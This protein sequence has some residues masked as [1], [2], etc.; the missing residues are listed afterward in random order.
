VLDQESV[1]RQHAKISLV[2]GDYLVEDL[3]SRN[4]TFVNSDAIQEPRKLAHG[5]RLRICELEFV[6]HNPRVDDGRLSANRLQWA[7]RETDSNSQ[8]ISM[9]EM[10]GSSSGAPSVNADAKLQAIV[11]I[12]R[13]LSKV[14]SL[15]TVLPKLLDGLFKIFSRA[16]R[17]FVL[18]ADADGGLVPKA[19]KYRQP[20]K[21]PGPIQISRTIVNQVMKSQQAILLADVN[22]DPRFDVRQSLG[23]TRIH[24]LMCAPLINSDNQSIGVLQLDS[25]ERRGHFQHT[26]LDLLSGVATQAAIAIDNA[27]LHEALVREQET[28]RDL[29][30]A[31]LVQLSLLPNNRPQIEGYEFF[32]FYEP[33]NQVGGDYYD[34]ISLSGGRL[35]IVLA[36][37]SGKGMAAALV[38]AKLSAVVRYTLASEASLASAVQ[39]INSAFIADRLES[40]FVTFAVSV[41]DPQRGELTVVNAGHMPPLLRQPTGVVELIG[42]DTS[43]GLPLGI[44]RSFAYRSETIPFRSGSYLVTLTDGFS[45]ALNE[46]NEHYTFDRLRTRIGRPV[47]S[48]A[49]LGKSVLEDVESFVGTHP[50]SDDMCLVCV[51]RS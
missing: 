18:L 42:Q 20:L 29:R 44:D 26:D 37:V 40:R 38:M 5:D 51:G 16:D 10:L 41:L 1:S 50:Q 4:R 31:H 19:V 27:R 35:A 11:E 24:S 25:G 46:K 13:S 47:Q 22:N 23:A 2:D 15:D 48:V 17:A 6:F 7:D 28:Q 3:R 34:Y 21:T 30:L 39:Q 9:M 8:I 32:D 33:A 36:D 49:D 45:D 14:L 12:A 43:G